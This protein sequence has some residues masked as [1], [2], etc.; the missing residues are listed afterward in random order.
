MYK[1]NLCTVRVSTPIIRIPK[2]GT[3]NLSNVFERMIGIIYL[4]SYIS[5]G[6]A[7]GVFTCSQVALPTEIRLPRPIRIGFNH[8]TVSVQYTAPLFLEAVY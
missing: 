3:R 2:F 5:I 7:I 6:T 8:S 4:L 1:L